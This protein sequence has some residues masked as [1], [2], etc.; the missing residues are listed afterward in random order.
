MLL[1]F[2]SAPGFGAMPIVARVAYAD[3]VDL[4]TMLFLRLAL[5]GVL[6]ATVMLARGF[7]WLLGRNLRLLMAMGAPGQAGMSGTSILSSW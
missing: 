1:L 7:R 6:M 2:L 5:A 4:T 3:G